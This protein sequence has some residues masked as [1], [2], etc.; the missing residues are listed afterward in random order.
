MTFTQ[1]SHS[2]YFKG[3][4]QDLGTTIPRYVF[5]NI[6]DFTDFQS[7]VRNKFFLG[8]FAV[9]KI[10]SETS[11][12]NGDATYQHLKIWRDKETGQCSLSFYGNSLEKA[13]DLDF[14]FKYIKRDPEPTKS[15]KEIVLR[16]DPL[17]LSQLRT[18]SPSIRQGYFSSSSES[19]FTHSR[20]NTFSTITTDRTTSTGM[21]S[22]FIPSSRDP[23]NH[24]RQASSAAAPQPPQP[25]QPPRAS[26]PSHPAHAPRPSAANTPTA[27]IRL[28][29]TGRRRRRWKI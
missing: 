25:Q 9:N 17:P 18:T 27:D 1:G 26:R 24:L 8:A 19:E 13:R 2:L 22:R 16:F 14:P 7:A 6:A 20:T 4:P 10:S 11:R 12:R 21:L 15:D 5:A 23:T 3:K 28:Q 29:V